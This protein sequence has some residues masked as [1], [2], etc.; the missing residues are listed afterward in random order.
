MNRLSIYV[1]PTRADVL[2]SF[3]LIPKTPKFT[4]RAD[5][6]LSFWVIPKTPQFTAGRVYHDF[7]WQKK[8]GKSGE[9]ERADSLDLGRY[10]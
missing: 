8:G 9:R 1:D 2:L 10:Y 7:L 5:V 3:W 6:L 4:T